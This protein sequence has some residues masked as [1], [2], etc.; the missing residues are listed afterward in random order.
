[1][2]ED[3]V[4]LDALAMSAHPDDV[5]LSCS[6]T[7][8]KL[9][10]RGYKTGVITLTQGEMGTRGSVE[11]RREEFAKAARTMGL[12]V[13]KA[14]D[15]PDSFVRFTQENLL[16][17]IRELR[18]YRPKVVFAPYWDVRHPDHGH[19]SHLIR[20]ASFLSGLKKIDT[21]QPPFRPT[22]VIYFSESYEFKPSF[23]VDVSSVFE[24]KLEAIRAYK[25]QFFDPEA[26]NNHQDP[27]YISKPEF[28]STIITRCQYWGQKIGVRYGECFL[29]REFIEIQDP[30]Q[31]FCGHS[32]AGLL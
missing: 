12:A 24:R 19:S 26:V 27:T 3:F 30:V 17:V 28:L 2:S 11:I 8:I 13:Q 23:I 25:S 9:T 18:A 22:K 29:V 16:K 4:Q 15:I 31:H 6:G 10:E 32:A 14:L 21:G 7:L 5:E 20:E 1:M